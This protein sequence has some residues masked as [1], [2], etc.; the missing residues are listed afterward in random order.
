[1]SI[2]AY[3]NE[4]GQNTMAPSQRRVVIRKVD[5]ECSLSTH[6]PVDTTEAYRLGPMPIQSGRVMN[7]KAALP[8]PS[9]RRSHQP[10]SH[11][12]FINILLLLFSMALSEV[13]VHATVAI[14][15]SEAKTSRRVSYVD[16]LTFTQRELS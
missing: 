1:M 5:E 3:L 13:S 15:H 2:K 16:L 4:E 11:W 8:E 10:S 9:T 6:S 7:G 12:S 14:V